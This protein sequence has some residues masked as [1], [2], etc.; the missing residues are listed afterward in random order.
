MKISGVTH[1]LPPYKLLISWVLS[2]NQNKS[3]FHC[4][5]LSTITRCY[6]ERHCLSCMQDVDNSFLQ[7]HQILHSTRALFICIFRSL[8]LC[9]MC[10]LKSFWKRIV[11]SQ[12]WIF[13]SV[14]TGNSL[15]LFSLNPFWCSIYKKTPCL[16]AVLSFW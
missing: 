4:S 11:H 1:R 14:M 7:E 9:P 6:W 5:W 3:Y 13:V 2:N 10:Y 15:H 12:I 8:W 16:K